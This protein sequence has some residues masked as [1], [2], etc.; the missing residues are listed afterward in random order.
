MEHT[1]G[2]DSAIKLRSFGER[3]QQSI[4]GNIEKYG[5]HCDLRKQ[6]SLLLGLGKQ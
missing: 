5:L 2:R 4:V 3:G 6:D 1:Y